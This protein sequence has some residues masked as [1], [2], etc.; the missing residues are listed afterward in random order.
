MLVCL[1]LSQ[2]LLTLSSFFW[3]L[4]SFCSSNWVLLASLYSKSLILVLASSTLLLI[5]CKLLFH[6][7][8]LSFLTGPFLTLLRFS[9]R[10][11]GILITSVVNS[12]PSRLLVSILFISFSGVL[13]SSLIWNGFVSSLWQPPCV[14]FYVLGRTAMSP[15]L[16]RVA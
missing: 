10:S 2:R 6:L 5:P 11:L 4:S 12:V 8:Y 16:G 9:L 14:C 3:I 15:G 13:F 1:K 7:V